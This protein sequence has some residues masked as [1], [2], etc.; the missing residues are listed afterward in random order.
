MILAR[1]PYLCLV[2]GGNGK[3]G[4]VLGVQYGQKCTSPLAYV[5][6]YSYGDASASSQVCGV[7]CD[8]VKGT[9]CHTKAKMLL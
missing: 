4:F 3:Y 7:V 5:P 9:N 6:F 8:G 1:I 2:L